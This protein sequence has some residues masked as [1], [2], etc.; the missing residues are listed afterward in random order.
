MKT[1]AQKISSLTIN[2][3]TIRFALLTMTLILFVLSAGAPG[4]IGGVGG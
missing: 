1:F 3:Q 2:A 4:C